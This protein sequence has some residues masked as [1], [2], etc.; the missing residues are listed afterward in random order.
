MSE[1]QTFPEAPASNTFKVRS[2]NGFEH[3]FTMRDSSVK[4]LL[5]KIETIE[6][7]LLDKGWTPLEQ[8]SFG[9]FPK[10]E[11]EYVEGEKCPKDGAR[12][13][14]ATTK[15]GKG[16]QKCENQKYDFAT[17]TVSGC[18]FVRWEQMKQEDL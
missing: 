18:D 6:K 5:V 4:D 14:K 7:A 17:K 16:F 11:K 13:I 2:T 1:E 9:G 12:L 15:A 8:K 10:K 3:L